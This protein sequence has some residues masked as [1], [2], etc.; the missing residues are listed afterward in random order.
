MRQNSRLALLIIAI[1]VSLFLEN[2]GQQVFG[3]DPKFF[4]EI[5]PTTLAQCRAR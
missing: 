2:G 5:I 3:A 4:P 1:G